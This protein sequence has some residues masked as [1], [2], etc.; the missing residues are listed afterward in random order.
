M[1][2][3]P[4]L[5]DELPAA[6]TLEGWRRFEENV[7]PWDGDDYVDPLDED[8]PE[9]VV[10]G[11][12]AWHARANCL[13]VATRLFFPERGESTNEAKAVCA[14]CAVREECLEAGLGEKS[15][16]WGGLSERERKRIRSE[17]WQARRNQ[18]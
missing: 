16:I 11:S 18:A 2:S 10:P 15:G 6:L 5:E 1:I 17:R 13:G 8:P 12:H 14:G 3:R 7:E 9:V 4:Q